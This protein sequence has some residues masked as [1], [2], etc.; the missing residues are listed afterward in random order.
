MRKMLAVSVIFL[1]LTAFGC[2]KGTKEIKIGGIFPMTGGS[3]TFGKS[4]KEGMQ[5][6]VDEFNAKGGIAID[7]KKL[8]IKPIYDD[9]AGQPE[10]AANVARKQIDQNRVVAIVGE[11]VSKNS[12]AMAPICQSKGIVMISP[13]STN[14]E[15]TQKGDYIFRVC[16]LD[17]FQGV[18]GARYAYNDL[19]VKKAAI[20]Y[21][22]ANDYN[23]GLAKFFS[24]EFKR[25]GGQIVASEAF[26]DEEKTV[27]FKAQ[28][29]KIKA[30]E[31]EFL[32]LPNYYGASALI[33]KQAKEIGLNVP[34]GGGDGW[35]SPDLVAIGGKSVEGG[36]FSNHFF[37]DDPHPE[38]QSFVKKY[39]ELYSKEPDALAS[40]AYDAAFVLMSAIEK[41]GSLKGANI[42]DVL[43][44]IQINGVTGNIT[45][46]K[47]R[48]PVKSAVIL[49]IKD[50]KQ[51]YLTTVNP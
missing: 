46:D 35:D 41:A 42:R 25:L 37:K 16:F 6:A 10:Q 32:Y 39:K 30:A 49:Q 2:S 3:A 19:K 24:E 40:L 45:F 15:V 17:S 4:S 33:M 18:V 50:G 27:D 20:L 1:I 34:A 28:L 31:P 38:V 8:L 5:I 26:T 23:K 51:Q 36:V 43:K 29:T 47:D 21:D 44:S 48:N 7:G 11:V 12:L 22:N 14:P 9:T 13:A